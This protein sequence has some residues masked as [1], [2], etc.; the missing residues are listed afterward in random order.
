MKHLNFKFAA[1]AMFAVGSLTPF[2]AAAFDFSDNSYI[3]K[4]RQET[5]PVR[6]FRGNKPWDVQTAWKN[7]GLNAKLSHNDQVRKV[8]VSEPSVEFEGLSYYDYLE[9]PDGTTWFY[10][11][12]YD[13]EKIEHS[14]W[15]TEEYMLGYT[16]T[17][18]DSSFQLVGSI[19]DKISLAE[20]ETGARIA[21]LD[22]SIS[23]TFFNTDSKTEVMVYLAMNTVN[24][25]MHY[26][27]KVYSIG[28]EKDGE[29][30]DVCIATM[31]GRCVDAFNTAA[32]TGAEDFYYTFVEDIYPDPDDFDFNDYIGYLNAAKTQVTV[33]SKA[34]GEA[35][36]SIFMQKDIYM[37]RYPGDTTDGIYL[38][39]KS[40]NG[41]PY[42]IFSQYEKPYLVD[43]TGF[44][45]D[46]SATKDNSLVIEVYSG[47]T[48]V[49]TTKIPVEINE[50]V[51]KINYT[52]YSIGS[53]AWKDDIDMS[54]NGT[55]QAPAFLVARDF[56]K[57]SNL[58]EVT[59]SYD[60][61]GNDGRII[62]NLAANADGIMMM[63][64]IA[65]SEPQA[66]FVN[67][68]GNGQYTFNFIDLY[69][70]TKVLSL[71]CLFNGAPEDALTAS[72]QRMAVDDFGNYQ[73]AFEM[74]YDDLDTDGND[75]KRIAWFGRDGS[76]AR[77]DRVNMGN[78][79]MYSTVNMYAESLSPYLYDT[80]DAME[81]AVLVKR[82]SGNTTNN[83][84][85]VVDDNGEWYAHF[86][87]ADSK[88]SPFVFSILPGADN[89]RLQMVYRNDDNTYNV[90][91]Y[92]LPFD[93][94]GGTGIKA[95]AADAGQAVYYD[96]GGR[97][98]SNPK[99]GIY[100]KKQGNS[101]Q[102]VIVD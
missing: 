65:G 88:G 86:S 21:V 102:K 53:V 45:S 9:A 68:D 91:V 51:D 37:T 31:P 89:S 75:I 92:D 82:A 54:V 77:I 32:D 36:P 2:D 19:K 87:D 73:Y 96:L 11:T 48:L 1:I 25:E 67:I 40:V 12:E 10:T 18:Y 84:F 63:N 56:T 85:I 99:S 17:I 90:Y 59:S 22:P 47:T 8:A 95:E 83:E 64:A 16:F 101:V 49:S 69:S 43:P 80:D 33:Y 4:M 98:V 41:T 71:P 3:A 61:Y 15:Y 46:E 20:G 29:G 76:L 52:F 7:A 93:N 97:R 70:G 34:T 78:D 35:A 60:I 55:P 58:E 6:P 72:C 57:A 27:N 42:F 24:Y 5:K 74:Q 23:T 13:I 28:G 26:Y 94:N 62:R 50:E 79:V 44:A 81:Y 14:E 38:I 100:V 39:T 30:N 66:L